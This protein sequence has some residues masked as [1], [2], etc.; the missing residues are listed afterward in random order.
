MASEA[1]LYNAFLDFSVSYLDACANP[2]PEN[3]VEMNEKIFDSISK[4]VLK[5]DKPEALP[6]PT[7]GSLE[8]AKLKKLKEDMG[9]E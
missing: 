6:S 1:D 3:R 4:V 2:D 8:E 9:I 5:M 7:S